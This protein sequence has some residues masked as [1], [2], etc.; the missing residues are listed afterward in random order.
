MYTT[1]G[2]DMNKLLMAISSKL[3]MRVINDG[4]REGSQVEWWKTAKRRGEV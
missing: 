4:E 1:N 3:P 2:G